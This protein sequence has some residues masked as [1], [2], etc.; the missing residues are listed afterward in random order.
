[1]AFWSDLGGLD[2]KRQFKFKVTFNLLTSDAQF[3]AQYAKRPQFTISDGTVVDF[4]DKK[5]HYPG[6]VTWDTV[7]I[8]FV[9]AVGANTNVSAATYNYLGRAGWIS[10]ANTG[11]QNPDFGTISKANSII[12]TGGNVGIDVLDSQGAVVDGWVL[13]NAFITKVALNDLD[14]AQEGILTATYTFRYDWAEYSTP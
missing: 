4:L 7:D 13:K 10:P 11:G 3:L 6:K 9:D 12:G 14:Y 8:R 5:F 2:P 1:M